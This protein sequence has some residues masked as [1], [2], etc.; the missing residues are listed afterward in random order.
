MNRVEN[1]KKKFIFIPI[2]VIVLIFLIYYIHNYMIINKI[3]NSYSD[4]VTVSNKKNLYTYKDNKYIVIGTIEDNTI[5]YLEEKEINNSKDIYYKIKDTNYYIDYKNIEKNNNC[6]IDN[7]LDNYE[8]ISRI[9]T[10]STKLYQDNKIMININDKIDFDVY[11]IEDNKYYVKYFN[12]VYYIKDS[13]TIVE[14]YSSDLKDISILKLNSDITNDKLDSILSLLKENYYDTISIT[15]YNRWSNKSINLSDNKV[16]LLADN[17]FIEENKSIIDKYNIVININESNL[18]GYEIYNTTMLDRIKDRLLGIKEEIIENQEIAVLNYH[19]FY[20]KTQEEC[21]EIICIDINDFKKQL[22]YL[23]NNNY[24]ILTMNEFNDWLD[25]KI[26]LPKKSVL[27]TIDDGAMG[28]SLINGNKLIPILEEYKIP[29]SLFLITGWWNIDNYK[30][31]YLEIYSHGDELHHNNYCI[32]K[33]CGYKTNLL[34]TEEIKKDLELSINK[35]GNN[36]AFC[37]PFYIKNN[38]I[39]NVLKETGFSLAFIGGNY[40]VKQTTDKYSIPRYIIYKNTSLES[41]INMVS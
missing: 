29:A 39:T 41:F 9:K 1:M 37:Y 20:E 36:L 40:K 4:C 13:Y 7:S 23:K 3:N 30:S 24:K 15:D 33:N 12:S 17:S 5:I 14:T 11:L 16:L 35:I 10:N 27:I 26:T 31:N 19:F 34:T 28:T 32:D 25:K 38:N 8:V 6:N 2:L 22:N 21:N 18:E